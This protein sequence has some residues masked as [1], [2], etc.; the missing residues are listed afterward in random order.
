MVIMNRLSTAERA[1]AIHCLCEGNS[2]RSTCRLTGFAKNTVVKLLVELGAAC[3][4]YHDEHVRGLKSKRV[5]CDEIWSFVGAKKKNTTAEQR[6]DGMGDAWTWVAL[7]A[8]AKLCVSYLVGGRDA[9]WAW[10][11]MQDVAE[12]IKG[13]VQLTTDGHKPYL[14]A[15]EGAFG[16]DV[17]FATLQ[18][19]Y[20]AVSE[21]DARRYSPACCIGC[22]MKPVIGDPDPEHV[23]TSFVE[24]QNLTMRISM[25]R[26]TRLTNAFS[27]KLENH[28]H[29]V[30]VYF[31]YYNFCRVHSTLRVTPAMEAGLAHHAWSVEELAGLLD[32][33]FGPHPLSG[34]SAIDKN[35][36]K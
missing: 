9:G 6:R 10:D 1:R 30:A 36:E 28:A 27:K 5:Q 34:G 18:K 17:D 13:R 22:E 20:G 4:R 21:E 11:F 15:V 12:R 35:P 7:D 19:I 2:I 26:F 8:D 29:A 16:A 32:G 33:P 14:E 3:S 23:S 31:M 24:R 25:R